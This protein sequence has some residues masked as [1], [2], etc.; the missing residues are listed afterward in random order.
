MS[1]LSELRYLDLHGNELSGAIPPELG[2]LSNLEQ[3]NLSANGLTGA[4]PPELSKLS[5]LEWMDLTHNHLSGS[6]PPELAGLSRL[7]SLALG[8][9]DLAGDIPPELAELSS[10]EQLYLASNQLTGSIPP[11]LGRLSNLGSLNLGDNRLTGEIPEEL[12]NLTKL[13]TLDLR[14]NRLTGEI[15]TWLSGF[16]N[17]DWL[18]LG[19]NQF[20][21]T[22]P[23]EISNLAE[24][25]LLY[26]YDNAL[27]GTIPRELG[28]LSKLAD[29]HLNGNQLTGNIPQEFRNLLRM[30]SLDLSSND[31]T[32]VIPRE[33][34]NLTDLQYLSLN[35]NHLTGSIPIE[36]TALSMLVSLHI[37]GNDLTG[38]IPWHLANKLTLDITHDGLP[39]CFPPVAEGGMFSIDASRLVD[40]DRQTI[41]AVGDA[42]SGKVMLDGATITYTHDGSESVTDSFTYTATDGIHST[43]GTVTVTVTPVNDP[44]VAVDDTASVNEGDTLSV[45]VLRLLDNDTDAENHAISLLSVGEAVNG[46]V[47][48]DGATIIY[49]HDGS[50]TTSDSF[51]YTVS[52]GAGTDTAEVTISV[53]PVN[54]PPIAA[55]D[56]RMVEEGEALLIEASALLDND[57][58]AENDTLRITAVGEA[59]NGTVSLDG[60]TIIYEHDGSE[61]TM[62]GFSYT[63][64]DGDGADI[65]I[66]TVTVIPVNDPPIAVA[67]SGEVEEGETLLMEASALLD[68]DTDAD[69]D[70]LTVTGVGDA[71]NG[72]VSLDGATIIYKHDG[73]ETASDNFTYT[74]SDGAGTDTA[75]VTIT[76]S[77]V[78]DPP[79][80]AGDSGAVEEGETL[81]IEASA[82]LDN[83]TDA[84]NDTLSITAVGEAVNGTVSLDGVTII[85][86][87]DGSET[88]RGSF[89]YTV[90]DGTD[91]DTAA[92]TVTVTPVNDP[93]IAVGDAGV[94][95]EG[96]TLSMEASALLYNDTDAENDTLSITAVGDPI[97][98]KVFLDGTT[99]TYE[100]DGSETSRGSFVY[101][102]SDGSATD[103]T[104]VAIWVTPV[105]DPPF[106]V[107]DKGV[108]NEGESLS[109]EASSLLRND[110]DT[111]NDTLTVTGVG[112]AVN[113]TVSLDGTNITYEHD[114]SETTTGT[115]TYTVSDGT[116]TDSSTVTITVT[117]VN[118]PPVA[119]DDKGAVNEGESLSI[120]AS[121]LL[122]NDT[123][124][125][126]DTLSITAVGNAV[127]G[128]VSLEGTT[129]TYTHD[130]S[131][132]TTGSFSY[133][134]S[135]G[136]DSD[137]TTVAI[138]VVPVD[139]VPVEADEKATTTTE[140]P[141]PG[142]ATSPTPATLQIS[143]PE[144]SVPPAADGSM[145]VALIVLIVVLAV[146][147]A[148]GG[149]IVVVMRRN[150]AGDSSERKGGN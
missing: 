27:T 123:D 16:S 8:Y 135:D 134:V 143:S 21:G 132:T 126:N 49:K 98:G 73:S 142:I 59:V 4:I 9:N 35:D 140:T 22:I 133:T 137:T 65:A 6:I 37:S 139:D 17:L 122:E 29:L 58:D 39:K 106:A 57:T 115:F 141:E 32:G 144:A 146:T 94:V 15:P 66:V 42:V 116:H 76:V 75:E 3:L 145:N 25:S 13:Y 23:S 77:P 90:S 60:V 87:H 112:N 1:G 19:R 30:E 45:E 96:E 91:T 113:G 71:V 103:A 24:L 104:E 12:A 56:S 138:E 82:L 31:L 11:E 131:G 33:L 54:D 124:V 128:T 111:E 48:L 43:I 117:P 150:R 46:E 18:S 10:L 50:E 55:G 148:G 125:E 88:S 79:I 100:H 81:L 85:Y 127:N 149:A 7:E 78:N 86:E 95:E 97:N 14:E 61:T 99:I 47:S 74:V 64:S 110:T 28:R 136:T 101:T 68:N 118:D 67:D 51:A 44:P 5:N 84:D 41:V 34:K 121:T 92:V 89:A 107:D 93:P 20:T 63:A 120:E 53:T 130:G 52:D 129:I 70:T 83:D 119:V 26:L 72:E 69:N 62:G 105:N 2:E 147:I 102:V 80:A 114:G 109:I 108:V 40:N 36:L 38:C